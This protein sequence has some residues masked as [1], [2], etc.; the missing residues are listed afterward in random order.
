MTLKMRNNDIE[1][2]CQL[3][4]HSEF[5]G[6]NQAMKGESTNYD[7]QTDKAILEA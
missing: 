7:K 3:L 5:G 1:E 6:Y 2:K 4:S